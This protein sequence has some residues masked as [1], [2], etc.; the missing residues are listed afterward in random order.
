MRA[1]MGLF[2]LLGI[3]TPLAAQRPGPVFVYV[4]APLKD[5]FVDTDSKIQDSV[6][7]VQRRLAHMKE[8]KLADSRDKADLV[9]TVLM[10]GVGQ[11]RYGQRVTYSEQSGTYYR[12][13]ELTNT[14]IVEQTL[15]VSAVIEVGTYRKEFVGTSRNIPGVR[16][17]T[18]T[19]CAANLAKD[20]KSWAVAN[21][22]QIGQRLR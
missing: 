13:A 9:L 17:G 10:R 18:W 11:E 21:R 4:S 6:R 19:E 14:P 3:C 16:W 20:L 15:W 12:N 22:D 2:L 1:R 8:F 7:D 5:G